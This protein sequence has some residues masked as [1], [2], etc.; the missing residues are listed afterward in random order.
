MKL[1]FKAVAVVAIGIIAYQLLK[2]GESDFARISQW[3]KDLEDNG[4]IYCNLANYQTCQEG[5]WF[6]IVRD[7]EMEKLRPASGEAIN[8]IVDTVCQARSDPPRSRELRSIETGSNQR[9][10][11]C[12]L[13]DPSSIDRARL[14]LLVESTPFKG[15]L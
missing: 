15:S 4:R 3:P 12:R 14:L 6:G 7:A 1:V 9:L 5:Q 10:T 8:A 11:L 2:E 13:R